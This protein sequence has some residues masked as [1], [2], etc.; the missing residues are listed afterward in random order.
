[1]VNAETKTLS[2]LEAVRLIESPSG[3]A[4]VFLLFPIFIG[5]GVF[6][7]LV[8]FLVSPLMDTVF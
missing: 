7:N 2:D 4:D 5:S 6:K 1:M 8:E 3:W